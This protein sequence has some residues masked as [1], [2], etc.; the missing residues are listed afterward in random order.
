MKPVL[1]LIPGMLNTPAVWAKVVPLLNDVADV[2]ILNV[3]TQTS[4]G[5]MATH[6]LVLLHDVPAE[7]PVVVCGFSMG[8]FVTIELIAACAHKIRAVCLLSTSGRPEFPENVAQREKTIAALARDFDKTTLGIARFC[9]GPAGQQDAALMDEILATMR[10]VGP[11]AAV[12]QNRAIMARGDHR[13]A[14]ARLNMPV[15]V[16][17]GKDDLVTPP[18]CSEELAALIPGAQL[19]WLETTGHMV[20]MEQP[21]ALADHLKKFMAHVL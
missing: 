11:D 9:T 19:K 21:A 5:D 3:Q 18:E 7:Q 6:A 14:L 20:P 17:C 10:A 2:R 4:I 12:A 16:L 15:L 13:A 1:L 8:G